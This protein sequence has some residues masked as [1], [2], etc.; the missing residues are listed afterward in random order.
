MSTLPPGP[1]RDLA[2]LQ[3]WVLALEQN[4]RLAF[5]HLGVKFPLPSDA[6]PPMRPEAQSAIDWGEFTEKAVEAVR[7]GIA[8]RDT[9][10][11][12]QI[13]KLIAEEEQRRT[14]AREVARL[15]K[16]AE[17]QAARVLKAR[18]DRK[19]MLHG[20]IKT[21]VGAI[22]TAAFFEAMKYVLSFHH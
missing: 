10:P 13:R 21:I 6:P 1:S 7:V 11:E 3:G 15:K 20:I 16:D 17:E 18:E 12:E 5:A 2:D 14:E 4:V 22:G 19:K 9:T 8:R